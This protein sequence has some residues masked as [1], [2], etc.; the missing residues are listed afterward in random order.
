MSALF[1][2]KGF[3]IRTDELN[4]SGWLPSNASEPVP[5]PAKEVLLDL[6]ITASDSGYSLTFTSSDGSIEGDT[7]HHSIEEAQEQAQ[8]QFAISPAEWRPA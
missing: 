4:H 3:R 5:F 2:I 7:W 6:Q 8:F 1:T